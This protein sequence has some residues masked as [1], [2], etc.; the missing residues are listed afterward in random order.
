[1]RLILASRSPRRLQLLRQIGLEPEICAVDV[2][3]SRLPGEAPRDYVLRL[4]RL[5][6]LAGWQKVGEGKVLGADTAVV[7]G[8]EILGKP[9]DRAEGIAMLEKLSGR[10]HEVMTGVALV[11]AQGEASRLSVSR[12]TFRPLSREEREAYWATGEGRDKAGGYAIQGRAAAFVSHMEGSYT[13]IV[14]LPLCETAELLGK[15]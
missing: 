12:V 7:L 11:C 10:T 1:M 5:K 15:P 14:G 2:D 3:E 4:A 6:A 9:G 13:G 8:G